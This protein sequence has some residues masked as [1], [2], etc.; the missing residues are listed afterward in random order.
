MINILNHSKNEHINEYSKIYFI[1]TKTDTSEEYHKVF[2]ISYAEDDEI[3]KQ[4]NLIKENNQRIDGVK[5]IFLGK[6]V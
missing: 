2:C 1:D 6:I 3:D 4:F 5:F